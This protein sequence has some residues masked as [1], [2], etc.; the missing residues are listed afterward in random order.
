M[1]SM[2]R[3]AGKATTCRNTT[4]AIPNGQVTLRDGGQQKGDKQESDLLF[5]I[6]AFVVIVLLIALL[7]VLTWYS[8][9]IDEGLRFRFMP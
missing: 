8:P 1:A 9:Q 5:A 3:N 6:K 4:D 2:I 7:T